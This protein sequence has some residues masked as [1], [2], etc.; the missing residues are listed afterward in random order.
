[1]PQRTCS[2]LR[3]TSRR[4]RQTVA[5][6]A[7]VGAIVACTSSSSAYRGP[8]SE[9]SAFRDP[10]LLTRAELSGPAASSASS[11]LEA[12]RQVRPLWLHDRG[13]QSFLNNAKVQVALDGQILGDITIL[14]SLR[15]NDV[16]AARILEAPDAASRYGM[17]AQSQRVIE[18]T[19]RHGG[20]Q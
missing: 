10:R 9:R 17:R 16:E 14:N 1:M 2:A 13:P 5:L 4:P 20:P 18:L 3:R 11:L 15:A 7:L 8:V 19:S 12:L 6:V